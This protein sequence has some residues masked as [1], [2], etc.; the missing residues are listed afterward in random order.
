MI[1]KI[2]YLG[3]ISAFLF[4]VTAC[5]GQG[6]TDLAVQQTQVAIQQTKVVVE[7]TQAALSTS[8]PSSL[9]GDNLF[10]DDFDDGKA[11][12]WIPAMGT[13]NV[14]EGEYVCLG[15]DSRA[16]VG[17]DSWT[18]YIVTAKVK[19]GMSDDINA[20]VMGRVQDANNYYLALIYQGTARIYLR[21]PN[22]WQELASVLYSSV[23]GKWYKVGL[24]FQGTKIK[25]YIDDVLVVTAEDAVILKGKI[26]LDCSQSESYFDD[27]NVTAI[28]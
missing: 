25:M 9:V 22:G 15:Y 3:L 2:L 26:G 12:E 11:D 14:V 21:T 27:V 19:S 4:I 17:Q 20:G 10:R 8:Q 28:K 1:Q 23:N 13:W 24:E 7:Q 6:M 16:L 18:D 5:S